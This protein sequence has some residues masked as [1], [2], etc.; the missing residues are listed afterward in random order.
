MPAAPDAPDDDGSVEAGSGTGSASGVRA[1]RETDPDNTVDTDADYSYRPLLEATGFGS[2][3][4]L[5]GYLLTYL[6]T[7]PSTADD[8]RMEILESTTGQPMTLEVVAWTYFNAHFVATDIPDGGVFAFL[9]ARQNVLLDGDGL[10][11]LLFV[12]PPVVL[13]GAGALTTYRHR[14]GLEEWVDGA[15]TGAMVLVGYLSCTV[16]ALVLTTVAVDAGIIRPVPFDA[17]LTAGLIYPFLFGAI[18]GG[19]GYAVVG[20]RQDDEPVETT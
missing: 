12:L 17:I 4:W 3:A 7:R 16:V 8:I 14:H 1:D 20:R 13:V 18:G 19:L 5:I 15:T 2:A 10:E 9:P 6:V 11:W